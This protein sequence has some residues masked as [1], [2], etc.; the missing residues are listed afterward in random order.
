VIVLGIESAT[1]VVGVALGDV[2]GPLASQWVSGRRR[3]AEVLAPA[4]GEVLDHG[5]HAL[6]D[7]D[8]IGIDVGPGLFTGLRVG[9]ATAKGLGLGL[10]VPLIAVTSLEVIAHGAWLAGVCGPVLCVVDARRAE[11]FAQRFVLDNALPRAQSPPAVFRPE[12]LVVELEDGSQTAPA[13]RRMVA[14]GDGALRYQELLG[15]LEVIEIC[16]PSLGRPAP[17]ALVSLACARLI[18]GDPGV[19]AHELAPMYLRE[20][21]ARSNWV[22]RDHSGADGP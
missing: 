7:L 20:A 11:V 8:A 15:A 6:G 21:D 19:V 2:T 12:D 10:G 5:G 18:A 14:L 4:I 22:Q 16:G 9:I 17:E 13:Q 3:H 1:E